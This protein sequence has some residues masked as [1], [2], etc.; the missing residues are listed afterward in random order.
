[1]A[2][3]PVHRGDRVIS[4]KAIAQGRPGV[5]RC[6]V[7][8]CAAYLVQTAHET[9]GAARTRSSLRPLFERAGNSRK[10]RARCAAGMRSRVYQRHCERSE[11]IHLAAKRKN[12]LLRL[13]RMHKRSAFV[14]DNDGLSCLKFESEVCGVVG[15]AKERKR[16]A[17]HPSTRS[18]EM[19]GTRKRAH[20]TKLPPRQIAPET[21]SP[22][23]LRSMASDIRARLVRAGRDPCRTGVSPRPRQSPPDAWPRDRRR[24]G[25]RP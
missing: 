13:A 14:A 19:V 1:M 20:P 22:P 23:W 4:R 6:P 15:W 21:V 7:C 18:R 10:T 11:A 9:A 12:G 3:K 2:R 8:S 24:R 5:L 25:R 17:H 16:R